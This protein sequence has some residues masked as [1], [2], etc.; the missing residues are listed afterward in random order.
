MR[1]LLLCPFCKGEA[2]LY[3]KQWTN[4]LGDKYYS[5]FA[6][7]IECGV[8]FKRVE[9][10]YKTED[11]AIQAAIEAW[12]TR[13]ERTCYDK[14][15]SAREHGAHLFLW[16]CS[17]CNESYDTEMDSMNYCPNCGAKVVEV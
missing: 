9:D 7:C 2:D 11:E 15:A 17:N 5:A 14:N 10:L 3:T 16:R 8:S 12:N 4:C 13:A 1:E 6:Y